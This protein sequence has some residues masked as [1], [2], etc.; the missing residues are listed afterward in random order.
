MRTGHFIHETWIVWISFNDLLRYMNFMRSGL[1]SSSIKPYLYRMEGSHDSL[2]TLGLRPNF[3]SSS[4]TRNN[5]Q[6]Q[7]LI[8]TSCHLDYKPHAIG[9]DDTI[10]IT[11]KSMEA[12]GFVDDVVLGITIASVQTPKIQKTAMKM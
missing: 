12:Q 10:H 6:G 11:P 5:S 7:R 1:S 9:V 4:S 2:K 8:S 3:L